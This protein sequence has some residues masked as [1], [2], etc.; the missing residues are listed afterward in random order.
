MAVGPETQRPWVP[1]VR[2]VFQLDG[3]LSELDVDVIACAF[4]RG[5]SCRLRI[6]HHCEGDDRREPQRPQLCIR[7]EQ[8]PSGRKH[9]AYPNQLPHRRIAEIPM[10]DIIQSTMVDANPGQEFP[11][12]NDNCRQRKPRT[13]QGQCDP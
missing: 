6:H 7:I 2:S 4:V 10:A 3:K 12:P 5:R 11:S 13:D 1:L 9:P 8:G